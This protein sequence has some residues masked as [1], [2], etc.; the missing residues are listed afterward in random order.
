MKAIIWIFLL[1]LAVSASVNAQSKKGKAKIENSIRKVLEEQTKA[2]NRGDI[3]DFMEGYW[4]SDE[5]IFI[6]GNNISKGWQAALNRYKKGYNK[7]E[8]MGTLTF[9]ELHITVLNKKN[10]VVRGRFTLVREKD[11]PTGLF[12][13]IFRKIKKIGWRVVHDHTS[14]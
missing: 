2:W 10:A 1:I 7:R 13:L 3:D 8:K 9:S 6:S 4:K 5:M 11:K 12:T 14:T